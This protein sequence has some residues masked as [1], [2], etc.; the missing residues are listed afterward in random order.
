[1]SDFT[2]VARTDATDLMAEYPGY[3]EMRSYTAALGAEQVALSWREMS[4]GT[5]GRGSY[6]HRHKTQEELVLV[7]DGEVTFKVGGEVFTAAA[8][9]AVRLSPSAY[10]SMHNDTDGPARVVLC[11]VRIDDVGADVE[12]EQDFWPE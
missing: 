7:I 5:G 3:G 11:S 2:K 9:D 6:G 4:P 10:R 8:G 1:M 12:F